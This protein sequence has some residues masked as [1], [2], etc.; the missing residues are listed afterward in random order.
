MDDRSDI[1]PQFFETQLS[2]EEE[3]GFKSW[4]DNQYVNEKIS[5]G[6][7]YHY[8]SNGFGDDSD[9]D[10][11]INNDYILTLMKLKSLIILLFQ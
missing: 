10:A 6:D 2:P 8:K 4:L 5:E 9:L 1:Q 7:Y 3:K 11:L